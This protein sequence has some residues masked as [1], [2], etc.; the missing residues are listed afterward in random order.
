MKKKNIL[1]V[2][3]GPEITFCQ[4]YIQDNK[5]YN[6]WSISEI[7]TM[8]PNLF[9]KS[10]HI[11]FK[12]WGSVVNAIK[13]LNVEFDAV[14]CWD[15]VLTHIADDLAKELNLSPISNLD[16]QPFRYKDRMRIVCEAMGI[17][18]PRYKIVNNYLDTNKLINWS[19]PLIIKP[20]SFLSSIGV[21]KVNTFFELQQVASQ[22]LNIKFP[23]YIGNSVYEL[24]DMYGLEPRILV[25]EYIEGEEYS[26]EGIVVEEQYYPLGITK[27]I[28]DE[29]QF[30]DEIGH[31]FPAKLEKELEQ[32]I[33]NWGKKL[34]SALKLNNIASHTEFKIDKNGE[35][36]LIEIG[37]RIGGDLIPRL[38]TNSFTS[39]NFDFYDT[40]MD[41]RLENN[42]DLIV[43]TDRYSGIVFF[44]VP[45]EK[46]GKKLK[47][48]RYNKELSS[49][50]IEEKFFINIGDILPNPLNWSNERV[51]Y[52]CLENKDYNLLLSDM[53]KLYAS[54]EV[55]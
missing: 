48:L 44:K 54:A 38:M 19:F 7:P 18:V 8:Y 49:K 41:A 2:G 1:V 3:G 28:T 6:F 26:L 45:S 13:E 32:N 10:I 22:M 47:G 21:K 39:S 46:Y 55:I 17:K 31:I 37:A 27:K 24:G 25:E 40:Y 29:A 52:L 33:H 12:N 20:T 43:E 23:V 4:D 9:K 11:N 16:S 30:V 42:I 35:I 34:H 51:A 36:I 14:V 5:K 50:I 15:E 53:E